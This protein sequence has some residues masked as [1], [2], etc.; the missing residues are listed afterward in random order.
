MSVG[1]GGVRTNLMWFD[2]FAVGQEFV[3]PAR[4]IT[5]TDVVAFAGLTGDYNPLHTDAEM[6]RTSPFGQRVAHGLLV[7]SIANGLKQRLGFMDGSA[8]AAL[9]MEVTYKA[10]V[11]FG[12]TIKVRIT[13]VDK[14]PSSKG[15]R[16]VITQRVQVV[17]QRDEVVQE[18]TH[19][20]LL[21]SRPAV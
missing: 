4:T 2:D 3:T 16:G 10:P 15:G 1:E 12:D 13:I 19:K 6:A 7:F 14:Q 9:A 11:V 8:L 18:G 20:T 17:N 5:E 21:A